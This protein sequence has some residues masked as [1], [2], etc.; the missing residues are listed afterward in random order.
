MMYR[1]DWQKTNI[2]RNCGAV[3]GTYLNKMKTF[4][5]LLLKFKEYSLVVNLRVHLYDNNILTMEVLCADNNLV[6]RSAVVGDVT[7][8]FYILITH[9]HDVTIHI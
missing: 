5:V 4:H 1:T 6:K 7:L 3:A 8:F 9:A 2:R